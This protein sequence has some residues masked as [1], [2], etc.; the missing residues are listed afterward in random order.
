MCSLTESSDYLN[1]GK[2]PE[3]ERK[4]ELSISKKTKSESDFAI[5]FK[6]IKGRIFENKSTNSEKKYF[7]CHILYTWQ[8]FSCHT[9]LSRNELLCQLF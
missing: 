5:I 9:A 8:K 3:K 4:K 1:V 7:F 6:S 2:H